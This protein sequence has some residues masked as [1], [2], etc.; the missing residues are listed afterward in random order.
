MRILSLGVKEYDRNRITGVNKI[1]MNKPWGGVIW[2]STMIKLPNG[3]ITSSWNDWVDGE[4]S[5]KN[6]KFGISFKL[7]KNSRIMEI[8]S[9]DDYIRYMNKY[10]ILD[11]VYKNIGARGY[12]RYCLD[13][14]KIAE[15]FDAFHL[16]EDAFWELRMPYDISFHELNYSDFYSYDAESWIIFNSD[17][18]NEGSIFYHN[19]IYKEIERN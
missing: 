12:V 9:I 2:G 6:F 3:E 5:N 15:D 1:E 17:C 10:K 8:A 7:H 16:T 4:L 18:I 14:V 13:F 11:P 19:N